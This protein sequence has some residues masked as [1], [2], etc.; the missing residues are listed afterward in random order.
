MML[1]TGPKG[2]LGIWNAG[3][4]AYALAIIAAIVMGCLIGAI[5]G[6]LITKGRIAP[7]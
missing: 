4:P 7:L 6:L 2:F 3:V 1:D 5:V